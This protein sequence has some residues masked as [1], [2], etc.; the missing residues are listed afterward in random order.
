MTLWVHE[1][2]WHDERLFLHTNQTLVPN[3][4]DPLSLESLGW[5]PQRQL[6]FYQRNANSYPL[7][8]TLSFFR[9]ASDKEV[10]SFSSGKE[11]SF[12][13]VIPGLRKPVVRNSKRSRIFWRLGGDLG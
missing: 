6:L 8:K 7:S 11:R 13:H 3:D 12:I 10:P 5:R 4:L 9:R 2:W 1:W